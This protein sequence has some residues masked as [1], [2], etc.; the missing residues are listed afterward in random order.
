[1]NIPSISNISNWEG[2]TVL[3]RAGMNVPIDQDGVISDDFRLLRVLPTISHLSQEGA[4]VIVCSHIGRDTEDTLEPV[5]QY[6]SKTI[7][8]EFKKD[9][10]TGDILQN[11]ADLEQEVS[12]GVEGDIWLLD[13]LRQSPREKENDSEVAKAL[14]AMIDIYVNESFSVSHRQHMSLDALAQASAVAVA[15][16]ACDEE[17]EQLGLTL[18]P[19]VH[20]IAVIS[21][22][23]FETK[24]P[25]IQKFLGT[26]QTVVVGGALANTLYALSGYNVGKS[27]YEDQ[28]SEEEKSQLHQVLQHEKIYLP[29]IVVC[30][31][32]NGEKEVK[33]IS[34]VG[35]EDYIHDIA[36]EGLV[37]LE[38]AIEQSQLVVWNGPLGYYEG[39]Y[40]EGTKRLLELITAVNTQS[41]I[42]GGNT[43]DAARDLGYEE[44]VS[45]LSTG[46]GAMIEYLTQ[47]SLPALEK[48][49]I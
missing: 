8:L 36:P 7:D 48:L 13:N 27:L 3:V 19:P 20:S 23:K 30:G 28:L 5:A 41:I 10:F 16:Y 44:R 49:H 43:V 26:Y 14:A 47:G 37:D 45:F 6:L 12:D 1:M 2:K 29:A 25:L 40:A 31:Q 17:V 21:G 39:G 42:G 22:N 9:F 46:G 18:D 35:D 34:E 15:G 32:G 38:P 33:H 11:I 24:L 4:K